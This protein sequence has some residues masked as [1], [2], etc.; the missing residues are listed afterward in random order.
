MKL[1]VLP[2]GHFTCSACARCCHNWHVELLPDEIERIPKLAW[3]VGDPLNGTAVT[4]KHAGHVYLAHAEDRG[5]VFLNRETRL[6]RIHAQFGVDAKPLG[7]RLYPFQIMP[8]FKGEASI[9]VRFGCPT[10]RKN[11]GAPHAVSLPEL[12]ELADRMTLPANLDASTCCHL[13]REQIDAVCEFAA[14][15]MMGFD[16]NDARAIFLIALADWL[17]TLNADELDREALGTA[18][19]QLKQTVDASLAIPVKKP[20]WLVRMAFRMYLGLHLR[21]DEDVLDGRAGRLGRMMAMMKLVLGF[22]DFHKLG[23]THPTGSV[24]KARLFKPS[25][26]PVSTEV[27]DLHW[28]MIA[29]KLLSLHFMGSANANRNLLGGMRSLA[30]LYPLAVAAAKYRAGNRGDSVIEPEDVDYAVSVIEHSFGRSP[31]L[32]QSFARSIEKVL[33]DPV[34]FLRVLATV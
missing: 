9:S 29:T 22:G 17:G 34:M 18:F 33:L 27:F 21:R 23:V 28:R 3:P 6:C 16:R 32:A 25:L 1:S 30:L 31:V 2:E 12:R 10:V 11:E 24:V 26:Q 4:F 19:L 15:L 20:G 14:T 13:D 8:T 5:C 7:C